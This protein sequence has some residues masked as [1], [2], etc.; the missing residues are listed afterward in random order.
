[1]AIIVGADLVD[2]LPEETS[3]RRTAL[4]SLSEEIIQAESHQTIPDPAPGRVVLAAKRIAVRLA[5]ASAGLPIVQESLADYSYTA[6]PSPLHDALTLT[7]D[8]RRLLYPYVTG[9]MTDVTVLDESTGAVRDSDAD[10][11]GNESLYFQ[12]TPA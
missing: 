4:A 3:E 8:E 10:F 5:A 2:L 6:S 12:D 7:D 11:L 9:S 1:M